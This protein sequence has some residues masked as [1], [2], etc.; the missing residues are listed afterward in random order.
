ILHEKKIL[1][2]A[3][4]NSIKSSIKK[5]NIKKQV[6]EI[7]ISL[8]AKAWSDTSK[9]KGPIKD[10]YRTNNADPPFLL[11]ISPGH[12]CNLSCRDCYAAS[13]KNGAKLS[14]N[15]LERIINDAKE[16]W[17]IKLIVLSGGEPFAY[18]SEKKGILDIAYKNPD[19][20]FLVFSNGTLIN[21]QT[22]E[23]IAECKN[24]TPAFSVEG[25]RDTTDNRR[26]AGIFDKVIDAMN[27]IRQS[28]A[29][30]GMSVTVNSNNCNEVLSDE[31]LDFFFTDTGVFYAFYFQYLP[32]G[33]NADFNLMP[34]PFQRL[35]FRKKVL[36]IIEEK[37][38]F[39]LDFANHGTLVNGCIAAGRSGGYLHIDWHGNVTPCVFLPY[40][41]QNIT[42]V[43]KN[44]G[45][46][47]DIWKNP[48]LASIR[49]WQASHG[50]GRKN[51][52]KK[53]SG[54]S[55]A[56]NLL[57]PCPYRDHYEEFLKIAKKHNP[58]PQDTSSGNTLNDEDYLKNMS[59][60]DKELQKIFDPVWNKDFLQK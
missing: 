16:N 42:D 18:H 20:L 44:G 33:R 48:F 35:E 59:S 53:N 51:N 1:A 11:V 50:H 57:M 7:I 32:M 14:W 5:K 8:W 26:G 13:N 17:G 58:K 2:L 30:F 3:V 45:N 25:M 29:P 28:G 37:K 56:S 43:Y 15:A 21:K 39:L 27:L 4:I 40:V 22:A 6:S 60:Y 31:F 54:L 38:L 24:I 12:A 41:A 10:F 46:I 49:D 19:L 9:K 34:S 55:Q 52:A 23:S 47:T 36:N